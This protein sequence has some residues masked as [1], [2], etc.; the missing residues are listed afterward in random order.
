MALEP[1]NGFYDK[2]DRAVGNGLKALK[3]HEKISF[4]TKIKIERMD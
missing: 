1:S 4:T 3:P 2:L